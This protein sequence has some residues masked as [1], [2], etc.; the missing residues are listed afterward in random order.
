M[1]PPTADSTGVVGTEA[2]NWCCSHQLGCIEDATTEAGEGA[3]PAHIGPWTP[4]LCHHASA[5]LLHVAAHHEAA[6]GHRS[7]QNSHGMHTRCFLNDEN[8]FIFRGV[9]KI[10]ACSNH[11]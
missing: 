5:A 1:R 2:E 4:G 8:K 9:G 3:Q 10:K 7:P 6:S 11:R